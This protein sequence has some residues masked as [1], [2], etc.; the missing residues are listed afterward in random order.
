M[1]RRI[2]VKKGKG[3]KIITRT[4]LRKVQESPP[5]YRITFQTADLPDMDLHWVYS[6]IL[7]DNH[8]VLV[9]CKGYEPLDSQEKYK[10]LGV[11]YREK[12]ADSRLAQL[13]ID[14][15]NEKLEYFRNMPPLGSELFIR[16]CRH[17]FIDR[18][19]K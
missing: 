18:L 1:A 10:I 4:I 9:L 13:A 3:G 6:A 2:T 8:Y 17:V 7:T 16:N 19:G 5:E 12:E 14:A 11:T 15:F